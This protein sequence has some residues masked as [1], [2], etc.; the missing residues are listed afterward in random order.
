MFVDTVCI[1]ILHALVLLVVVKYVTVMKKLSAFQAMRPEQNITLI[2][3]TEQFIIAQI[4]DNAL[5]T[6]G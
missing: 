5:K 1:S 2:A 6:Q 3:K 4:F